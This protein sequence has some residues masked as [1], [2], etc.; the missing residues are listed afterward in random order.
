MTVFKTGRIA[1]ME[2]YKMFTVAPLSCPAG[3]LEP[4]YPADPAR[5]DSEIMRRWEEPV[6]EQIPPARAQ[7]RRM[8]RPAWLGGF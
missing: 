7:S 1:A 2:A 5:E 4:R 3:C 6:G 8:S